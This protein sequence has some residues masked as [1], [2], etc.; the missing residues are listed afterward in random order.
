MIGKARA[1][2]SGG[3]CCVSA[4]PS[5]AS[6]CCCTCQWFM[7][8]QECQHPCNSSKAFMSEAGS[9]SICICGSSHICCCIVLPTRLCAKFLDCSKSLR[10]KCLWPVTP[11]LL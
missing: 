6:C 2:F 10:G 1:V 3:D 5:Q 9:R 11:A 8:L 4:F 7:C